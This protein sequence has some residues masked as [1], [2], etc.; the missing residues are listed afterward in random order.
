MHGHFLGR[1]SLL[2]LRLGV[3]HRAKASAEALVY[4]LRIRC[5]VVS[6]CSRLACECKQRQDG[7]RSGSALDACSRELL[8]AALL[9]RSGAPLMP[10]PCRPQAPRA[11]AS[12]ALRG[13]VGDRLGQATRKHMQSLS[14]A[15]V[16]MDA[17]RGPPPQSSDSASRAV[18]GSVLVMVAEGLC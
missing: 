3:G 5:G 13:S 15:L 6:L 1:G 11:Q 10:G 12:G 16:F 8:C 7:R 4:L 9:P 14:F 18:G 17:P 2:S